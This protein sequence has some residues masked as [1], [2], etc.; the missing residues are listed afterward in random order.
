[1]IDA[2]G[3]R[4]NVGIVLCRTDG[5]V[6]W[7]RRAGMDAWQFPQGG[8]RGAETP[9]AAMLRE[10]REETG[11]RPEHVEVIG[12]TRPWLRYRLP[13]RYIR[14]DRAP[15]CIGQKQIWFALRFLGDDSAVDLS[16][17]N[18]PE[19]E[20]WRWVPYWR[21]VREVVSFKRRVYKQAL[22]ELEPLVTGLPD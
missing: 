21:P 11:L 22:A 6:F 7:G 14:V 18:E 9:T 1:M 5:R 20:D 3:F 2:D 17:A 19:F 15:L 12:A 10:L 8:I 13:K 16:A 4:A